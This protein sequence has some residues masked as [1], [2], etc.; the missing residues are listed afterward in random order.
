[1]PRPIDAAME[2]DRPAKR[3]VR[4]L[5][6]DI[7]HEERGYSGTAPLYLTMPGA[8]GREIE[9][10]VERGILQQL[11]TGAIDDADAMRVVAVESSLNAMAELKKRFPGLSTTGGPMQDLLKGYDRT[12]MPD[13]RHRTWCQA[14]IVNLDFNRALAAKTHRGVPIW[15]ELELVA[16]LAT[17]HREDPEPWFLFLTVN[18]S[19]PWAK[20]VQRAAVAF[21]NENIQRREQFRVNCE[22]V[23]GG[24]LFA[25]VVDRSGLPAEQDP[26][27]R[28][29]FLM[30]FVPKKIAAEVSVT[31]WRL[32]TLQN[33]HYG[34]DTE[35][36]AMVT[37]IF[38]LEWDQRAG[39][40]PDAVYG[41][42]VDSSLAHC[43]ELTSDGQSVTVQ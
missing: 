16:K 18:A 5:W 39:S 10:L 30:A 38:R 23:L 7:V 6:L 31:G 22:R 25:L 24:D 42:A 34:N 36:A 26:R 3:A 20:V 12:R 9:L 41:E 28:Q 14:K 17:L 27:S 32:E 21:L 35:H 4:E 40:T 19:I 11:D 13:G 1:M 43:L 33:I 37:W 29:R 8:A 15:A 2:E